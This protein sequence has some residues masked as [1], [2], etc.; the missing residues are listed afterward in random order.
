VAS[1]GLN[2][3]PMIRISLVTGPDLLQ[4]CVVGQDHVSRQSEGEIRQ[5]SIELVNLL[6]TVGIEWLRGRL[7][8]ARTC[9]GHVTRRPAN[10][11]SAR[12][13]LTLWCGRSAR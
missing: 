1:A 5:A 4:V 10:R 3:L 11:N 7:I 6:N 13:N 8:R 9:E 12:I 2:R